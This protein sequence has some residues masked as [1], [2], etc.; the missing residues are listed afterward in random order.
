V[1]GGVPHSDLTGIAIS[2]DG[3]NLYVS[4]FTWGGIFRSTDGGAS[5]TRMPT[6]G[7]GSDRVWA[8]TID[9]AA[10]GRLLAASS[11]GGVH[12]YVP[13]AGGTPHQSQN[14]LPH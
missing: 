7:L 9:P 4:D 5:W 13:A 2:P 10:P 11:A 14:E 6:D 1:N 8:M 12:L 3:G